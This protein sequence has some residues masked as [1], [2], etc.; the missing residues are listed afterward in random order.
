MGVGLAPGEFEEAEGNHGGGEVVADPSGALLVVGGVQS[1]L[2][3]IP[4]E[5][6]EGYT[7]TVTVAVTWLDDE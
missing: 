5:R 2:L 4:A 3:K 6:E 1:P 7:I